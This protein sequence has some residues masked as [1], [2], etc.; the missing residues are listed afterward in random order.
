MKEH[1]PC[2]CARSSAA[3][4]STLHR[5]LK[6]PLACPL[7]KVRLIF[8]LSLRSCQHARQR[9]GAHAPAH[10]DVSPL[11]KQQLLASQRLS[12]SLS[13]RSCSACSRRPR[14]N[15]IKF[16]SYNPIRPT[17]PFDH[18]LAILSFV[19][20]LSL[21]PYHARAWRRAAHAPA[22]NNS[23]NHACRDSGRAFQAAEA[24]EHEE[25]EQQQSF[26]SRCPCHDAGACAAALPAYASCGNLPW[27]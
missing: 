11:Q 21:Q 13:L 6:S 3:P 19:I 5:E 24:A 16:Y 9:R 20:S 27:C 18:N 4:P 1:L 15:I 8:S 14:P 17:A 25:L 12:S 26:Q 7:A 22:S 2:P 10:H 23:T